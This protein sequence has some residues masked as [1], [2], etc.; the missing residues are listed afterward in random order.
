[1]GTPVQLR[2]GVTDDFDEDLGEHLH[3]TSDIDGPLPGGVAPTLVLSAGTHR[4]TARVTDSDGAEAEVEVHVTVQPAPGASAPTIAITSPSDT[5]VVTR[6]TVVTL[7]ATASDTV[8]GDLSARIV[9]SEGGDD[10]LGAG[11]ILSTAALDDGVNVI[12]AAVVNRRG[13]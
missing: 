13:V 6:G 2:A 3:W 10:L 4:L 1:P 7:V 9:W 5:I 8:D 11:P 12:T